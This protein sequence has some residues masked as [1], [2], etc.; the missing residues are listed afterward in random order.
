M[1]REGDYDVLIIDRML[2]KLDGLSLIHGL[3]EQ[4]VEHPS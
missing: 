2:P 3:R 4:K 1:A